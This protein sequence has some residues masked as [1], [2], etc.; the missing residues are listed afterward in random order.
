[1]SDE[2]GAFD[3]TITSLHKDFYTHNS[4]YHWRKTTECSRAFAAGALG[5]KI[6][7]SQRRIKALQF[8]LKSS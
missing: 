3:R 6:A 7:E 8:L 1:M 5:K 2:K 4:Q